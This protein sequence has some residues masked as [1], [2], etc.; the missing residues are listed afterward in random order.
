[1]THGFATVAVVT[2]IGVFGS[3]TP[4]EAEKIAS[5]VSIPDVTLPMI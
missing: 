5:A 3:S 1:L 2:R 4:A